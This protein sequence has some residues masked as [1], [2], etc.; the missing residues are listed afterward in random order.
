MSRRP[1][2]PISGNRPRGPELTP[3]KRGIVNGAVQF[4]ATPKY[5][6]EQERVP[7]STVK[8]TIS[9]APH[10]HN[11]IS[12][13][14]SGRPTI[15]NDRARRH[16]IHITRLNPQITYEDLKKESKHH[17]SKATAYHILRDYGLTNWLAK[18]RPLLTKEV[19]AKRLAWC[20][21]RR[22]WGWEE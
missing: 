12:K 2:G 18:K 3:C 10:R 15:V 8:W 9:R 6:A 21:E 11:G 17:Y 19:A 14:R 7:E 22:H 5:I 4:G 20:P 1:L 13:P 16:I